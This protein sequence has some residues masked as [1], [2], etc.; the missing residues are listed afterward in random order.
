MTKLHHT[1]FP[2]T[3]NYH[4]ACRLSRV[5]FSFIPASEGNQ[6]TIVR[7]C[8]SFTF[9]K[10]SMVIACNRSVSVTFRNAV[11]NTRDAVARWRAYCPYPQTR[12]PHSFSPFGTFPNNFSTI[13]SQEKFTSRFPEIFSSIDVKYIRS[14]N[15]FD[16]V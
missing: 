10:T 11:L 9:L 6:L 1:I 2:P 7:K 5:N 15:I 14:H 8:I 13:S 16:L 3:I 12:V 4:V